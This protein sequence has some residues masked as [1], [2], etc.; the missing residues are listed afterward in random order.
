MSAQ[1]TVTMGAPGSGKS[2]WAGRH[3]HVITTDW[4]R[5][6]AY[7]P[8]TVARIFNGAFATLEY[9]LSSGR[10]VVLDTTAHQHATRRRALEAASRCKAK[11]AL[12][13]FDPPVEDC[14]EAQRGRERPVPEEVVR[15]IHASVR[16]Q[17]EEITSE[18]WSDIR[19]ERT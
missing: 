2:T 4:L 13:V 3:R 11:A 16:G 15:A 17:L 1:L 7:N 9:L 8:A 5:S 12:V 6:R 14:L 18:G 19:K 10:D